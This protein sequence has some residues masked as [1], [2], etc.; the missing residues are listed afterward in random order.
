MSLDIIK[1][2]LKNQKGATVVEYAVILALVVLLSIAILVI[3]EDQGQVAFN[4]VGNTVK[5]FGK[6]Q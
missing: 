2:Y 4:V 6:I 3:L 5:D 1:D